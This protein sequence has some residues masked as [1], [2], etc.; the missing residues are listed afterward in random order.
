MKSLI[1]KLSPSAGLELGT[2]WLIREAGS[3]ALSAQALK[4]MALGTKSIARIAASRHS[5]AQDRESS[6]SRS[7]RHLLEEAALDS[8]DPK[9]SATPNPSP[10]EKR[11]LPASP[12]RDRSMERKATRKPSPSVTRSMQLVGGRQHSTSCLVAG[13]EPGGVGRLGASTR[14]A[15]QASQAPRS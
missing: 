9:P 14:S 4:E 11:W 5:K 3:P 2:P 13:V 12:S 8:R 6:S 7:S 15:S 10:A 1:S